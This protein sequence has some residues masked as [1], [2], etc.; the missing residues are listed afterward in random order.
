MLSRPHSGKQELAIARSHFV[1]EHALFFECQQAL[2]WRQED[3][4][5]PA[6]RSIAPNDNHIACMS[7]IDSFDVCWFE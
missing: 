2:V 1:T 3:D 4:L 5:E 7:H 6:L